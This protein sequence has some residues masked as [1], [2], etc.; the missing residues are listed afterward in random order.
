[1]FVL[2]VAAS[3][4][5]YV[6]ARKLFDPIPEPFKFPQL[7]IKLFLIL[8]TGMFDVA[9]GVLTNSRTRWGWKY[10]AAGYIFTALS[11]IAWFVGHGRTFRKNTT[12]HPLANLLTTRKVDRSD[13]TT[14]VTRE[15]L[16][17]V[18]KEVGMHVV[19]AEEMY[20]NMDVDGDGIVDYAEFC[21]RFKVSVGTFPLKPTAAAALLPPP[22][23]TL[24]FRMICVFAIGRMI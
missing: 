9:F 24:R 6:T 22:L 13:P 15:D 3:P 19:D 23:F 1:M 2:Y 11:F 10:I 14:F 20:K 16:I 18:C 17:N 7:E 8:C 4:P 5:Q 21:V 12:W